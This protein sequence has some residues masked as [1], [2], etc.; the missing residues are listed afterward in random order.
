MGMDV[1]DSHGRLIHENADGERQPT[2]CHN[3]HRLSGK[4]QSYQRRQQRERDRDHHDQSAAH[5]SQKQEDHRPC[6]ERA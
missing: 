4:P 6:Q 1:L 5:I 3:V 2:Q